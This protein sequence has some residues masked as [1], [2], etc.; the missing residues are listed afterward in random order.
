MEHP[1]RRRA[2]D[3]ELFLSQLPF[4]SALHVISMDVAQGRGADA[5]VGGQ[6]PGVDEG[7]AR[8]GCR[9]RA[10]GRDDAVLAVK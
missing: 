4:G 6:L 2:L 7:R 5:R 9:R 8:T 10:A 1:G 3:A